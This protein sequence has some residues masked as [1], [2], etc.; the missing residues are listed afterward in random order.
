VSCDGGKKAA[1]TILSN[2]SQELPKYIRSAEDP[3]KPVYVAHIVMKMYFTINA[4][5]EYQKRKKPGLLRRQR[6]YMWGYKLADIAELNE[7]PAKWIRIDRA[8]SGG[9]YNL[10]KPKFEIAI[11]FGSKLGN[12]IK[13]KPNQIIC[14]CWKS[15]PEGYNFL[16][17][18]SESL[19]YFQKELD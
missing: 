13:Y 18:G 14:H 3:E 16:S 5:V 9:W 1:D 6:D 10:T 17:A 4:L 11:L 12:L 8:R 15:I 19:K 2:F 7:A